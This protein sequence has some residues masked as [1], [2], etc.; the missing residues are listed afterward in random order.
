MIRSLVVILS[1]IVVI[2]A[3]LAGAY[4]TAPFILSHL[5]PLKVKAD[6]PQPQTLDEVVSLYLAHAPDEKVS[7]ITSPYSADWDLDAKHKYYIYEL[8]NDIPADSKEYAGT[9][10]L[11]E[12]NYE[13]FLLSIRPATDISYDN[14]RQAYLNAR[15]GKAG[16][17]KT[18]RKGRKSPQFDPKK[19]ALNAMIRYLQRNNG[20]PGEAR[21]GKA[22]AEFYGADLPQIEFPGGNFDNVRRVR[23]NPDLSNL[24][25]PTTITPAVQFIVPSVGT[26]SG[27]S[28]LA[29]AQ[30]LRLVSIT[31]DRAWLDLDLLQNGRS[32]QWYGSAPAFFGK[33]G[34]LARIPIRI[35]LLQR[36]QIQVSSAKVDN[37]DP[38]KVS[39]GPFSYARDEVTTN[40]S[41]LEMKPSKT[42]WVVYA[43]VSKAL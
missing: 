6:A 43:V 13:S 41:I 38:S 31:I 15:E 24:H 23:T 21:L 25:T 22:I 3:I 4:F 39:I 28:Q 27:P 11:L 29:Q 2:T 12:T 34:T 26:S 8:S 5:P 17:A 42:D 30:E 40:G 36:P 16:S 9:G 35:V 1:R 32:A 7:F 10:N 19:E 18:K 20:G 33:S 37:S 14:L